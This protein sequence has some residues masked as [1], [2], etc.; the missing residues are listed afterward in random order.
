VV[1]VFVHGRFPLKPDATT[2]AEELTNV[3]KITL[4]VQKNGLMAKPLKTAYYRPLNRL[5]ILVRSLKI[6]KKHNI[7]G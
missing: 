6:G 1:G 2:R 4:Q 5:E 7:R 3:E